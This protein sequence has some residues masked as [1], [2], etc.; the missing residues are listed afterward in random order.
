[1]ADLIGAPVVLVP[2]ESVPQVAIDRSETDRLRCSLPRRA[3]QMVDAVVHEVDRDRFHV[4]PHQA[5]D[6]TPG[7]PR[8][9]SRFGFTV[10]GACGSGGIPS[11]SP[12]ARAIAAESNIGDA[13]AAGWF[14]EPRPAWNIATRRQTAL[15][16]AAGTIVNCAESIPDG[17]LL[18]VIAGV[19]ICRTGRRSFTRARVAVVRHVGPQPPPVCS[20]NSPPQ[21]A[22]VPP[23]RSRRDP[24]I[25]VDELQVGRLHR[26][27]P[28]VM[29]EP[30]K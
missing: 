21:A 3:Q 14:P 9:A 26:E 7:T 23:E 15:S 25:G 18:S 4:G 11:P 24:W 1:M 20:S 17:G 16:A 5:P 12:M 30:E 13:E 29:T 10:G 8:S 28:N 6:R 2:L 27:S 19:G 22:L